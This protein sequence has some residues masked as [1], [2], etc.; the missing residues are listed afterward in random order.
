MTVNF[1]PVNPDFAARIRRSF[2]RQGFMKLLGAELTK[3]EPG[4][5]EIEVP[6]SPELT[7]QHGFFHA[8][9]VGTIAD[10]CGGYASFSLMP[11]N[12]SVL[13]VEYKLNLVAPAKGI[14]LRAVG[15]VMR[16][17]RT[18]T[19]CRCQVFVLDGKTEKLCAHCLMTVMGLPGRSDRPEE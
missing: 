3:V 2:Q 12:H 16:P 14:R 18:I 6:F 17:G 11:A 10:N 13:T 4:L 15:Q 1:E 8:G 7:Q 5:V 9:V 19:V